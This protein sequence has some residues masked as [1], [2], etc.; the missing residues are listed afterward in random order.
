[1]SRKPVVV[2]GSINMDLV[3]HA[4]LIPRPGQTLIG[5][6][7]TTTP[8]G[9][10]AN[11]AVA[12][13]RLGYPVELIGMVGEDVFG[14]T[15][16]R[17]LQ[18][19]GVNT[20]GIGHVSG[21]SGVALIVV[22]ADGNNTIVVVPGA[23]SKVTPAVVEAQA[24]RIRD[25]GMVLCQLEVPL[26]TV[27]RASEI[28]REAGVPFV[29]DPAPAAGLPEAIWKNLS[30]ITPNESEAAYYLQGNGHE[31]D[32]IARQ[33][34]GRG[35]GG[36]VL[37]R[38]SEGAFIAQ[39]KELARWV[40][41]FSVKAVDTVGAGDAFNGGFAVA[42]LEGQEAA[43]AARFAAATAAVSVTRAGA[44]EAMATRDEVEELLRAARSKG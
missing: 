36:V 14:D 44:Q 34:L 40:P 10:G 38:G 26:E 42:L 7:F 32:A 35:V 15:L 41:P 25:A 20:D 17:H 9:K 1:M 30:W 28:A 12:V 16:L 37:K 13:A 23:N 31:P 4:S 43:E 3:A 5:D 19:K 21:P 8:G 22:A 29:L 6:D 24:G 11:Q 33:F 27:L 18:A 39:S 2:V